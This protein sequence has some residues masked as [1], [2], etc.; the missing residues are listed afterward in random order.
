M[1][2]TQK[3]EAAFSNKIKKHYVAKLLSVSR[4]T[5]NLKLKDNDFSDDEIKTL[6]D[7]NVI[8]KDSRKVS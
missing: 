1:T 8:E 2:T 6:R 5:L 4:P 3:L 7:N